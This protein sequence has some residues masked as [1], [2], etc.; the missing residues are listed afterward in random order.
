VTEF[1]IDYNRGIVVQELFYSCGPAATQIVLDGMGIKVPERTLLQEIEAIENPGRGDD[2]DGTDYVG[3]IEQVLDRRVPG[4]AFTSVYMPNDPPTAKQKQRLWDDLVRSIFENKTG[5]VANIVAPARNRP[6]AVKGSVPPPYPP[7]TT[8]HYIALMG[9]DTDAKAVWVAD[10]AAFGGITGW[11]APFD[12][13]G[14]I[15]TL[16]P[17]KGYCYSAAVKT[18]PPTPEPPKPPS[19]IAA[20]I[21]ESRWRD[22]WQTHIEWIALTFGEPRAVEEIIAGARNGDP[23]CV[24]ALARLEEVNPAA[25][26]AYLA[27]KG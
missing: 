25:L 23:R 22:V 20:V 9:I 21:T 1:R 6:R 17:P 5:V 19:D 3:L 12:G 7:V 15:C 26:T 14:S 18:A 8:W 13:P 10:S 24:R 11:W 4:A 2:K 16:I 27:A